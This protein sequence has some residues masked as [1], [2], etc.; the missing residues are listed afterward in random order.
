VA[1]RM[2]A[3]PGT[4]VYGAYSAKL[5]LL[6]DP[7]DIFAVSRNSFLPPPR[8]DSSVI[9]LRRRDEA[10]LLVTDIEHYRRVAAVIDACFAQRRKTIY[11]NLRSKENSAGIMDALRQADIDPQV[12]AEMLAPCD[13]VRLESFL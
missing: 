5:Q 9:T 13:F 7:V 10:D 6:A 11:N 12:R 3:G 8:V 1:Q 2:A 4:K